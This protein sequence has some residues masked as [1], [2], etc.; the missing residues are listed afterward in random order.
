M[1][2]IDAFETKKHIREGLKTMEFASLP[3][4]LKTAQDLTKKVETLTNN[5]LAGLISKDPFAI[6][7]VMDMANR[8]GSMSG[9]LSVAKLEDAILKV[10]FQKVRAVAHSLLDM[11]SV[12]SK[13]RYYE[14]EETS[15]LALF[16]CMFSEE[17]ARQFTRLDPQEVYAA[18]VLRSY[19]R[20]LMTSFLIHYYREAVELIPEKGPDN[21]F[22]AVFGLTP[23][24]LTYELLKETKIPKEYL[25]SL[26]PLNP[27]ILELQFISDMDSIVILCDF[28]MRFTELFFDYGAGAEAFERKARELLEFFRDKVPA[29]YERLFSIVLDIAEKV[30][31][32]KA[33][34]KIMP[35][36]KGLDAT[37]RARSLEKD[38]PPPPPRPAD[39]EEPDVLE[40]RLN[41]S[42]VQTFLDGLKEISWLAAKRD[43]EIEEIYSSVLRVFHD[44]LKL[45]DCVIFTSADRGQ[46][47][48]IQTGAG[49][50]FSRMR[51]RLVL[52]PLTS[53]VF[54]I[55]LN[56]ACDVH[57]YDTGDTHIR[58]LIPPWLA[59]HKV[60]SILA[61]PITDEEGCV[62]AYIYC[63]RSNQTAIA[64]QDGIIKSIIGIRRQMQR[65]WCRVNELPYTAFEE[66]EPLSLDFRTFLK[67][68]A[69]H[70]K[71]ASAG[72]AV[73]F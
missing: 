5:E 65:A 46:T 67:E 1:Y 57:I 16:S 47:L 30:Q 68:S 35:L 23:L 55:S 37:L 12:K 32:M 24:E 2:A 56:K 64:M 48:T 19:G 41:R 42:P 11:E 26:R 34:Y 49:D 31:G 53:D 33:R 8:G 28:S 69:A 25:R 15:A 61:L 38:P 59:R 45:D 22:R 10:G 6:A 7:K 51:R 50:I 29:S 17:L 39:P 21:A 58:P 43:A 73:A 44:G 63:S 71:A 27:E 72:R 13:L 20:V 60:N 62:F 3:A 54:G 52:C 70:A 18:T 14:Q 36:P 4:V 40:V 9:S 66:P